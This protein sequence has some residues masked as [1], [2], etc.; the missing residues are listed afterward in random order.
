VVITCGDWAKIG[1]DAYITATTA[2]ATA[3]ILLRMMTIPRDSV[4]FTPVLADEAGSLLLHKIIHDLPID[5]SHPT[6]KNGT[7][8][9]SH[10][11]L[12]LPWN[13]GGRCRLY[14]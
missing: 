13:P 7:T 12:S 6:G 14:L 1:G 8:A 9:F 2:A 11:V 4:D 5:L 3:M 10:A